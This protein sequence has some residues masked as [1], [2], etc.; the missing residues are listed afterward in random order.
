MKA[1]IACQS[2]F[3]EIWKYILMRAERMQVGPL[4]GFPFWIKRGFPGRKPRL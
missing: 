4:P 2:V 1:G 3:P